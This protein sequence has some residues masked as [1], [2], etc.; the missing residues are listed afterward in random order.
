M[1]MK[2]AL[3]FFLCIFLFVF[4]YFGR[5]QPVSLDRISPTT[6]EVEIKGEVIDP[7]VYTLAWKA[8]NSD[9]IK[10][11]GGL[12]PGADTSSIPFNQIIE[13]GSILVVPKVNQEVRKISISTASIEE[14]D[15]LPGIGPGIAKRIVEYRN[16]IPF[17]CVEDIMNVKGIG[18]KLFDKIKD[19]ICL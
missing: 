17:T 8:T 7:G 16:T 10:K 9:L 14:L 4:S 6:K 2:R 19:V 5:Y 18:Q 3:L 11:A 13:S 12:K 1:F 15:E